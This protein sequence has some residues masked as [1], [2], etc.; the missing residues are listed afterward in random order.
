MEDSG[1]ASTSPT[2]DTLSPAETP[3]ASLHPTAQGGKALPGCRIR[4]ARDATMY[5]LKQ[6]FAPACNYLKVLII[7]IMTIILAYFN[8]PSKYAGVPRTIVLM[9]KGWFVWF[10]S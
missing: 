4:P 6:L 8:L 9:K 1:G 10:S 5:F 7:I 3:C 2:T